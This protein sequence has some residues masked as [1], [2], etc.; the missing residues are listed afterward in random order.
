M[1]CFNC[2]RPTEKSC[3]SNCGTYI[4][5][6]CKKEWHYYIQGAYLQGH[7]PDCSSKSTIETEKPKIT[8]YANIY[9]LKNKK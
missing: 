5:V 1:N 9:F 8:D 7:A 6:T 2:G 3:S 4:C